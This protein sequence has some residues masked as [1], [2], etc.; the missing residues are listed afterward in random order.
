MTIQAQRAAPI[1]RHLLTSAYTA[2]YNISN[3]AK[4]TTIEST[5]TTARNQARMHFRRA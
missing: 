1:T 2:W 5:K 3:T 4:E